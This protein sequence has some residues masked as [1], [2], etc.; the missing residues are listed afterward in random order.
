MS[1]P[2][3]D[4]WVKHGYLPSPSFGVIGCDM[5]IDTRLSR[6]LNIPDVNSSSALYKA[7]LYCNGELDLAPQLKYIDELFLSRDSND[8]QAAKCLTCWAHAGCKKYGGPSFPEFSIPG[9]GYE[10]H[11]GLNYIIKRIPPIEKQ[12]TVYRVYKNVDIHKPINAKTHGSLWSCEGEG[13]PQP[14]GSMKIGRYVSTSLSNTYVY[15][16]FGKEKYGRQSRN[17]QTIYVRFDIL[18]GTRVI[19]I[20]DY[21]SISSLRRFS[22]LSGGYCNTQLEILLPPIANIYLVPLV[23]NGN[24]TSCNMIVTDSGD[25]VPKLISGKSHDLPPCEHH[26]VVTGPE[27]RLDMV[28]QGVNLWI[29]HTQYQHTYTGISP[30]TVIEGRVNSLH[31]KRRP[32]K[33][34]KHSAAPERHTGMAGF[35]YSIFGP[36]TAPTSESVASASPSKRRRTRSSGGGL[37]GGNK[38]GYFKPGD[39]ATV[40]DLNKNHIKLSIPIGKDQTLPESFS[41][42]DKIIGSI[43]LLELLKDKKKKNIKKF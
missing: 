16:D 3:F 37:S 19:P 25:C 24:G 43:Y 9:S 39:Y 13:E 32:P 29:D 28:E 42:S 22:R 14:H 34:R 31:T 23:P 6:C 1:V 36:W 2:P 30:E 10:I 27:V 5:H 41:L 4:Y 21:E 12:I 33:R 26:F 11:N 18:P 20:L 17:K 15:Y 38:G 35:L 40:I 7:Q 8:E